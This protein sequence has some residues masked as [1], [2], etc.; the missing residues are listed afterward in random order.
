MPFSDGD[1][2]RAVSAYHGWGMVEQGDEGNITQV[3]Y[4]GRA[5]LYIVN[6]PHGSHWLA[7][8]SDLELVRSAKK[9]TPFRRTAKKLVPSTERENI[10]VKLIEKITSG[11]GKFTA[12][13][14]ESEGRLD[15]GDRCTET[16]SKRYPGKPHLG[17]KYFSD[18]KVANDYIL[19]YLA[20]YGLAQ[21]CKVG[22]SPW[23]YLYKPKP[24]LM[25]SKVYTDSETEWTTTLLL[26]EATDVLYTPILVDAFNALA[27]ANGEGIDVSR[28]GMHTAFLQGENGIYPIAP[29]T[30]REQQAQAKMFEN[31][32]KSMR[33]L[34]PALYLLGA[35]RIENGRGVTRST[36][37]RQPAISAQSKYSAIAY[38][39]GA[40]EFRIFDTCYDNRDQVLDNI[41]VMAQSVNKYWHK[42][43]RNPNISMDKPVYFGSDKCSGHSVNRLEDLYLVKEHI[44]LLNQGLRCIKPPYL[45]VKEIKQA[46]NFSLTVRGVKST[47]GKAT[48]KVKKD[49]AKHSRDMEIQRTISAAS[50][51]YNMVS[52]LP[53][54]D[55]TDLKKEIRR[56]RAKANR[57][58]KAQWKV[59]PLEGF[60]YK[61]EF[62]EAHP[63]GDN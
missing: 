50:E 20:K 17:C 28:S 61:A 58:G 41:V 62:G 43:Y 56:L 51:F 6:F 5:D 23:S 2:V 37:P 36:S 42:T 32:A 44:V 8:E 19:R 18:V 9:K 30:E 13:K 25:F 45:T 46:R 7:E 16:C 40:V 12:V 1:R 15:R 54:S 59:M 27:E 39:Y 10:A 60:I 22:D 21:R 31:F 3:G 63:L 38:R 52:N 48:A 34:L 33:P 11:E 47:L 55:T 24:P 57:Y 53:Y 4:R 29:R 26:K 14:I 49:Y 35:S